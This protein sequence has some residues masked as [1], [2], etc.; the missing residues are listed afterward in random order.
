MKKCYHSLESG[1]IVL[2]PVC[3]FSNY[4]K[5]IAYLFGRSCPFEYSDHDQCI[6]FI[7]YHDPREKDEE[8]A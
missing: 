7:K 4:P 2:R 1:F 6:A 5:I 8:Q 3:N